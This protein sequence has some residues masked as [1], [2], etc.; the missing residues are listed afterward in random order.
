MEP[1]IYQDDITIKQNQQ[2]FITVLRALN[3]KISNLLST[4]TQLIE[5]QEQKI[6]NRERYVMVN[7]IQYTT[8]V[9]ENRSM[10]EKL[11]VTFNE[12][13]SQKEHL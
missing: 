2:Q 1:Y 5:A 12:V 8:I 10:K 7:R 9:E 4:K 11:C 3:Q 6:M 13:W